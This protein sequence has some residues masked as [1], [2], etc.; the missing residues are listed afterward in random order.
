MIIGRLSAPLTVDPKGRL[1]IPQKVRER[2]GDQNGETELVV[3]VFSEPCIKLYRP[4]QFAYLSDAL[5]RMLGTTQED[6]DKKRSFACSFVE[7]TTDKS[8]RITLPAFLLGRAAIKDQV[9]VVGMNDRVE[10]W[11]NKVFETYHAQG[12]SARQN[13][14]PEEARIVEIVNRARHSQTTQDRKENA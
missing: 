12:A 6:E 9:I 1:V 10:F 2:L 3:G 4:Q 11:D 8:G 7:V 5:D 14:N 13:Q